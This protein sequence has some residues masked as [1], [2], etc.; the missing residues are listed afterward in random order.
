MISLKL[1]SGKEALELGGEGIRKYDLIRWNLLN[2]V[3]VETRA[4]LVQM[5]GRLLLNAPTYMA[6]Y[7]TYVVNTANL[8]QSMYFKIGTASDDMNLGANL[9]VNSLYKAA[10]CSNTCGYGKNCMD[11]CKHQFNEHFEYIGPLC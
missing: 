8:P 5:G 1:W 7:P 6:G 11:K 10:P 4:N 2:T 3:I 9:V